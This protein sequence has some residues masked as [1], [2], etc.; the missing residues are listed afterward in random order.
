MAY[1]TAALGLT[2]AI[3][4]GGLLGVVAAAFGVGPALYNTIRDSKGTNVL[5]GKYAAYAVMAQKK[6]G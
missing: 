2:S 4:T 5:E 1:S 6:F 3:T